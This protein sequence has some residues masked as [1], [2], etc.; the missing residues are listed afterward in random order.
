M[1]EL[2]PSASSSTVT[3]EYFSKWKIFS[4][5]H[6]YFSKWKIMLWISISWNTEQLSLIFILS[7]RTILIV[8]MFIELFFSLLATLF[9]RLTN[10]PLCYLFL[11]NTK[12]ICLPSHIIKSPMFRLMKWKSRCPE[13][14]KKFLGNWDLI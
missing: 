3:H 6:E 14:Q 2:L 5:T 1:L 12:Q 9:M 10:V 8:P 11:L 4:L 7:K 13:Y